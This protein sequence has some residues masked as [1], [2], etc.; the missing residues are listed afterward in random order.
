[1][2]YLKLGCNFDYEL[3]DE[4]DKLNDG[5]AD[6]KINEIYGSD[7]EHAYLT[8]RPAYRLPNVS[9]AFMED[10]VSECTKKGLNF[11][12]TM[13]SLYP[14]SKRQLAKDEKKIIQFVMDL[15]SIG[16]ATL[17]VSS[18]LVAQIVRTCSRT[19]GIEVSTIANIDSVT[20]IK[21]WN[22]RYNISKVCTSLSKNRS[23]LFLKN[24]ASYCNNNN[25]EL[26][27]LA[28]EFCST[29]GTNEPYS[30]SCIFRQSCYLCHSDNQSKDDD[31][32]LKGYPMSQCMSSRAPTASWL[33]CLFIRPEDL[34][35]Y[36]GLGVDQFKITGRTGSTDYLIFVAKLYMQNKWSGNLLSLW[37]PLQTIRDGQHELTYRH[38]VFIDNSKLDGFLDFWKKNPSHECANELCGT[39]CRYCDDYYDKLT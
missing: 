14:G 36:V 17:T 19:I 38:P 33:K 29:G 24:A 30:T 16:V 23:F 26:C 7:R 20:Q 8:A 32:L 3:L 22:D 13:N 18:P 5:F 35:F 21:A 25:I 10:Y 1:M 31:L 2:I 27:V 28:N 12:Y 34:T 6:V 39:T 9:F 15:E 4:I 11:N 37:K